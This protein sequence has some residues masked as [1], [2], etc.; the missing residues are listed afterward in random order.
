M[1]PTSNREE[2]KEQKNILKGKYNDYDPRYHDAFIVRFNAD[3]DKK[4]I[5]EYMINRNI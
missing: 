2:R 5:Q 3:T 1:T 4:D